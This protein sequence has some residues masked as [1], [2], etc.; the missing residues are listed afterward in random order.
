MAASSGGCSQR[1]RWASRAS[2]KA[3]AK[4]SDHR[5][6]HEFEVLN[7]RRPVAVDVV[8]RPVQ[9][10]ER[11]GRLA[12]ERVGAAFFEE[13]FA[14]FADR[15][16]QGR[17]RH[18]AAPR[19]CAPRCFAARRTEEL[20]DDLDREDA[21]DAAARGRPPRAYWASP[22]SRSASASRI[23]SSRSSSGPSG[24]SGRSGTV[25]A[26]RSRSESQPSGR[27]SPSTSSG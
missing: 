26:A 19:R 9:A 18:G 8:L 16:E 1:R 21:G 23:T 27:R 5:D 4:P 3:T 20:G 6:D 24:E 25:S 17:V 14:D 12:G 10:E 13:A 11:V 22:W 15:R 2:A 7:G